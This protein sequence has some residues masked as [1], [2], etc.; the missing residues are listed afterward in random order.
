MAYAAVS[1][2]TRSEER[3]THIVS[4]EKIFLRPVPHPEDTY[5]HSC[6]HHWHHTDKLEPR[7]FP[8][9]TLRTSK[10]RKRE[11]ATN[12]ND[13]HDEDY[14]HGEEEEDGG[15]ESDC[16]IKP[17]QKRQAPPKLDDTE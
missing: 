5:T 8:R 15:S 11:E 12:N 4:T 16:E 13:D 14:I 17:K 10:K 3:R 6:Y 2:R 7:K 9:I 1:I